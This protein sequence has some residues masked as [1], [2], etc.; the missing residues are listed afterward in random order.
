MRV[1]AHDTETVAFRPGVMAPPVVCLQWDE[2]DGGRIEKWETAGARLAAWLR[3]PDVLIVGHNVAYDLV[4]EMA[5][6]PELGPLI[7]RALAEDRVTDTMA[8]ERLVDIGKGQYRGKF[9]GT[10]F[11]KRAYNL[12]DVAGRRT[13][14]RLNKED[15]WRKRYGELRDVPLDAWPNYVSP[16]DGI[17]GLAALEYAL[18]DGVATR[19]V[20]F[21]QE[22]EDARYLRNEFEQTRH[23]F[24]RQLM[25]VYGVRTSPEAV[26]Q[27]ARATQIAID[28]VKAGLV[29]AGLVRPDGSRNTKVAAA[30]MERVCAELG[31]EVRRNDPT[32]KMLEK[33]PAALGSVQLDEDACRAT[34]DEVLKDYAEYT[35]LLAVQ[36][37]DVPLLAS[38]MH[39][40]RHA[41]WEMVE[42]GRTS[43][44]PNWQNI[45]R[46][47]G[48]RECFIPRQGRVFIQSDYSQLELFTLAQTCYT[49]LG[50]SRLRELLNSGIDPHTDVACQILGI[51]YEEGQ[52][53]KK[54]PKEDPLAKEFD[55]ARQTA[56]VA[57][58]GFPGGLG[59]PKLVK[60][61]WATYKV[62]LDEQWVREVL[63]PTWFE[64]LPEMKDYFRYINELPEDERGGRT[65][66]QLFVGRV[67]ANCTYCA[68]CN[69]YFQ[70]LGADV[71][72]RAGWYIA[73][74]MYN[75]P[76]S[77]LYGSR[78]VNFIH[79]EFI[80][81]AWE[82]RAPEAAEEMARL[83]IKGA[84]ELLPDMEPTTEPS[85]MAYWSKDAKTIRDENGR[86][87]VWGR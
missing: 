12:G 38:A 53:R 81:E 71:A 40:P 13:E 46:L 60:F 34:E 31:L 75:E 44:S 87:K 30:M 70:G 22:D 19:A 25:A 74:A 6:W 66:E 47:K 83:M 76:S 85:L 49:L 82:D 64:A 55:D 50:H 15:P 68:A 17:T 86:L 8:R 65:V 33:D 29:A 78:L 41:H 56:K 32:E 58:F 48:I 69:T 3:D 36:S 52:R 21:S 10:K 23:Y 63:K 54:L 67:R 27:L 26:G 62:K 18:L 84:K 39:L 28:E 37:K 20:F 24:W 51:P 59:A 7:W 61:A 1:I 14:Y 35:K 45:R 11:V 16:V 43:C 42:S 73:R 9:Y 57:N 72:Q 5:Q 80:G 2:G 4:C 79:D 77:P